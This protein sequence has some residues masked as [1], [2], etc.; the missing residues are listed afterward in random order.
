MILT[1]EDQPI[2]NQKGE[3]NTTDDALE[4]ILKSEDSKR[5]KAY[6]ASKLQRDDGFDIHGNKK[7]LLSKYDEEEEEAMTLDPIIESSGDKDPGMKKESLYTSLQPISDYIGNED[8]DNRPTKRRKKKLRK[9]QESDILDI[10]ADLEA[11]KEDNMDWEADHGSRVD[12]HVRLQQIEQEEKIAKQHKTKQFDK[13]LEKANLDALKL[14]F[15]AEDVEEDKEMYDA[16]TRAQS[17]ANQKKRNRFEELAKEAKIKSEDQ[18]PVKTEQKNLIFTDTSE[19]CRLIAGETQELS[20]QPLIKEDNEEDQQLTDEMDISN[21]KPERRRH[22]RSKLPA[23]AASAAAAAEGDKPEDKAVLREPVLGTGLAAALN[24]LRDKGDL[25]QKF[26]WVGRTNDMKKSRL[27]GV[28]DFYTCGETEDSLEKNIETALTRKDPLGRVLTPKEAFRA[29]SYAFH[30]K[31][32]SQKTLEKRRRKMN[33]DFL[34]NRIN[35]DQESQLTR[36]KAVQKVQKNPFVVLTGTGQIGK[37]LREEKK[38]TS[39]KTNAEARG[40]FPSL[41]PVLQRNANEG[42]TP[43]EGKKK[44]EAMLG[45]EGKE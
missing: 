27:I 2:L 25:K 43:L 1:L 7:D 8:G 35:L 6:R 31:G 44:V 15:Q 4:N 16:L 40:E 30:G 34:A 5:R 37:E 13:A 18:A 41:T 3:L 14:K 26:E 33:D 10:V 39:K 21:S 45:L 36:L 12:R 11:Q 28:D 32:P 22:L 29:I 20:K 24:T 9:K 19:F 17:M 42:T 38:K 23:A